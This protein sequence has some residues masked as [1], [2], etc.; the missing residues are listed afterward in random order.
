MHI[1]NTKLW[2]PAATAHSAFRARLLY[3]GSDHFNWL[4]RPP[5]TPE[6]TGSS[7]VIQEPAQE[8]IV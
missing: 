2:T 7:P 3:G 1:Q 6:V 8:G 5:L 4:E